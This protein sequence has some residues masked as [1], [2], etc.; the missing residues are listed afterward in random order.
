MFFILIIF[1][2]WIT[3]FN[4]SDLPIFFSQMLYPF[5]TF[6]AI[7]SLIATLRTPRHDVVLVSTSYPLFALIAAAYA[8]AAAAAGLGVCPVVLDCLPPH[9]ATQA[10]QVSRKHSLV[11]SFIHSFVHSFIHLL[12]LSLSY[13]LI[14]LFSHSLTRSF[15]HVHTYAFL[16]M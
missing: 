12:S 7:P 10:T 15:T 16:F 3:R 11:H 2:E 8:A 9:G 4:L 5:A 14:Y 1:S 6:I 13:L